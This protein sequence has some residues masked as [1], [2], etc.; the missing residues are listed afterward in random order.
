M[1]GRR[2][3]IPK[4]ANGGF[5]LGETVKTTTWHGDTYIHTVVSHE[6]APTLYGTKSNMFR[7]DTRYMRHFI[8]TNQVD[9]PTTVI[10]SASVER[11]SRAPFDSADDF[12][13]CLQ[14]ILLDDDI[15][16]NNKHDI[17]PCMFYAVAAALEG[18]SFVNG[19]SQNTLS[20]AMC[21]FH[22]NTFRSRLGDTNVAARPPPFDKLEQKNPIISTQPACILGTDFKAG[23]TKFKT[24]R[25]RIHSCLG[26]DNSRHC[27][28]ETFG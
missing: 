14:A 9:G 13:T 3:P 16:E 24:A 22:E 19:G 5:E 27:Q 20:D 21:E 4:A 15:N 7:R 12:L 10:W 8:Q 28:F 18:C 1:A 23:R 25:G 11:P 17:S 2:W 26:L 6:T